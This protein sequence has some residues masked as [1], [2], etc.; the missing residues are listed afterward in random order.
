MH[1]HPCNHLDRSTPPTPPLP[2]NSSVR[3]TAAFPQAFP[4]AGRMCVFQRAT[5]GQPR[6]H[7]T[8]PWVSSS[9]RHG[10]ACSDT[11]GECYTHRPSAEVKPN[12]LPQL[13]CASCVLF[14]FFQVFCASLRAREVWPFPFSESLSILQNEES[15]KED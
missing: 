10:H 4:E 11:A 5:S 14:N 3:H 7:G 1:T 2:P 8:L 13:A 9:Y 15:P 6:A 12:V